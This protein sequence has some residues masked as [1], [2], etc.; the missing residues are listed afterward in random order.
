MIRYIEMCKF[1][2]HHIIK[3]FPRMRRKLEDGFDTPALETI[4]GTGYRLTDGR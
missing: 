3:T 2:R 1:M 4:W